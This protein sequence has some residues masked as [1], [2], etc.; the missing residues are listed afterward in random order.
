MDIVGKITV[1]L[2][3]HNSKIRDLF[4]ISYFFLYESASDLSYKMY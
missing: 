3:F 2:D 1:F 4:Q